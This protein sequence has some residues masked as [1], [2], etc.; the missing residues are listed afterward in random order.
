MPS[1]F[2]A[3]HTGSFC[4]FFVQNVYIPTCKLQ[5]GMA[6]SVT[7]TPSFGA[8][9]TGSFCVFFVQYFYSLASCR[10]TWLLVWPAR[11][12]CVHFTRAAFACSLWN[13]YMYT[14]SQLDM[15]PSVIY[16]H[17]LRIICRQ[18]TVSMCATKSLLCAN[19]RWHVP[20]LLVCSTHIL[21][22]KFAGSTQLVCVQHKYCHVQ[23]AEGTYHN[24]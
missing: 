5:V 24:S 16:T 14:Y 10:W 21:C 19:C 22:E 17:S 11:L 7:C 13:M 23:I 18:H 4:F 20:W 8:L 6:P 3:L 12:L 2:C 1:F 15:A 9:H